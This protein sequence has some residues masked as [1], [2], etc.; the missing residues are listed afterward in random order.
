MPIKGL[1]E[2]RR[3]PRI[4]KIHLGVRVKPEGKNE[5]PKA[6]DYLVFDPNHPQ[7]AELV[8]QYGEKPTE[9]RVIFPLDD[10]EKFAAQYYRLYSRS[11]GLVCKG[12]GEMAMRM[13]DTA[14]GALANR[15]SKE[16]VNREVTCEGRECP[17]YGKRGCGEV[18]NLQ[19]LLPEVSGF[20]V[21]Q[22][23]TGSINSILNVNNAL[24]L[25]K[26]I[27]GRVSMVP[28]IL[29]LEPKEV[30]NPDDGKKKTVRVLN[31]RSEDNMLE[32]FRKGQLPPLELVEGMAEEV[33]LPET[34]TAP[35]ID[36]PSITGP[37]AEPDLFEDEKPKSEPEAPG[38][39]KEAS[40]DESKAEALTPDHKT[41]VVPNEKSPFPP[42]PKAGDIVVVKT[43]GKR[44]ECQLEPIE[45]G[46][47]IVKW[48]IVT[49][50]EETPPVEQQPKPSI[51][52]GPPWP[53]MTF[54][55]LQNYVK[56]HKKDMGWL[57]KNVGMTVDEAKAKPY[58]C[59]MEIKQL[60]GW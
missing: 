47:D 15:D 24:D 40:Q 42:S 14:T 36:L 60:A 39:T 4:G 49:K 35:F 32:A 27:Y 57:F 58:D 31:I 21:W 11:R 6:T 2:R 50:P 23:D 16:V 7:Y 17:D 44:Y 56:A 52:S 25:V 5:Y 37:E 54:D 59:A 28:L 1:T 48:A 10:P 8:E 29:A 46:G 43:T 33:I 30:T 19:F 20:G 53:E 22:I 55:D 9:L 45:G 12:D 51:L 13:V 38:T 3:L 41:T 34:D 18:M 26:Q